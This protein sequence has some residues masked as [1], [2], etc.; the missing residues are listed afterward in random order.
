MSKYNARGVIE[1]GYTFDSQAEH[2][3]YGQLR[4][5]QEAG[6]ISGLAVHPVFELLPKEGKLRAVHYEAD[7]SYQENGPEPWRLV[8][9]DVKGISTA[10]FR[11]KMGLFKRRYPKVNVRIIPA[12]EV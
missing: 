11:L 6:E 12:G 1:D 2:R 3:R 8:V 4:L 5:Q 9:E 7:F 10:V